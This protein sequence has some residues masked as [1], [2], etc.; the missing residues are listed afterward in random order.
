MEIREDLLIDEVNFGLKRRRAA[1]WHR[2]QTREQREVL[3]R[4]RVAT[5]PERVQRAAVAEEHRGLALLNDELAA[6][7]DVGRARFRPAMDDLLSG[8]VEEFDDR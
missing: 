1:E 6:P 4:Q 5:R 2:K 8:V 7:L 3:R